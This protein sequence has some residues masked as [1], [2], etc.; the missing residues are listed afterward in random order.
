[1]TT[2]LRVDDN[3][4][5]IVTALRRVGASVLRLQGVERGAPDLC[6]GY[7]NV[8]RLIEVKGPEG[9][10]ADHQRKWHNTWRGRPVTI[11]RTVDEALIAIGAIR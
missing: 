10:V 7:R 6:V 3:Q 4:E 9:R 2:A 1:M 11:V 8:D 5:Q